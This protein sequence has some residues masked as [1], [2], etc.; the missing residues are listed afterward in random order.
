MR[1]L[2]AVAVVQGV[3]R[4]KRTQLGG[5]VSDVL[6][7]AQGET[8]GDEDAGDLGQPLVEVAEVVQHLPGVHGVHRP[9]G[10]GK[11]LAYR[12]E[13]LD[14]ARARGPREPSDSLGADLRALVRLN[15]HHVPAGGREGEGR[16]AVARAEVEHSTARRR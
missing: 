10:Q 16:H 1:V 14:A 7:S 6:P 15:G 12:V 2:S 8:A 9:V 5:V 13:H 4:K 11:P 3:S